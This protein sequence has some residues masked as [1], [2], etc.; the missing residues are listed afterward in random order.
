MTQFV[1]KTLE[2]I[3]SISYE[4]MTQQK[5]MLQQTRTP[6]Y[7]AKTNKELELFSQL[8]MKKEHKSYLM[9]FK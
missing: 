4:S 3:N 9:N 5:K 2:N 8:W 1:D 7:Q 6:F